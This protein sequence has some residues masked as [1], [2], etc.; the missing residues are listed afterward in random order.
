MEILRRRTPDE[1]GA[2]PEAVARVAGGL[3][4]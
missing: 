2:T 1:A 3:V 4:A